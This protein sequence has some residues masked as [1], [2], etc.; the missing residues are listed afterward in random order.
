MA[1][2]SKKTEDSVAER[3]LEDVRNYT[4]TFEPLTLSADVMEVA[5]RIVEQNGKILEMNALLMQTIQAPM[6]AVKSK[7]EGE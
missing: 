5:K 6:W 1:K 7:K 3:L 2:S 4:L